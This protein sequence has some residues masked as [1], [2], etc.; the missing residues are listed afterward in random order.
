MKIINKLNIPGR[1]LLTLDGDVLEKNAKKVVV[2]GR[3]FEFDIAYDM[4][5]TIGIKTDDVI[6]KTV[7]FI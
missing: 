5:N 4:K 7:E 2:D 6:G 1:T 3:E